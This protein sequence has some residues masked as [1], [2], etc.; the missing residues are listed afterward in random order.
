MHDELQK[1]GITATRNQHVSINVAATHVFQSTQGMELP[2]KSE[3]YVDSPS[4]RSGQRSF[5]S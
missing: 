4:E 1:Y 3:I 5:P 2:C